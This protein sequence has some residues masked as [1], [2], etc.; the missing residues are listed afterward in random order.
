MEFNNEPDISI[1][2]SQRLTADVMARYACLQIISEGMAQVVGMD[3]LEVI[4]SPFTKGLLL[5]SKPYRL[6]I[7]N[8]HPNL[9]QDEWTRQCGTNF[10]LGSRG[11]A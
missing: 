8:P 1:A 4:S 9:G 11:S 2:V 10:L 5:N 7:P 3:R 6:D